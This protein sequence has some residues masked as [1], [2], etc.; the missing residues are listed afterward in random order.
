[1]QNHAITFC[2]S[3]SI[4]FQSCQRIKK[5]N[6]QLNLKY[7]QFVV[8]KRICLTAI[9]ICDIDQHKKK[10]QL[11]ALN[12]NLNCYALSSRPARTT[13]LICV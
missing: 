11:N 8:H 10:G 7:K 2:Q 6:C 4:I 12:L 13:F 5:L 3:L 1:M 9:L